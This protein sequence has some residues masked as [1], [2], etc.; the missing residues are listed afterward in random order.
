[1][2]EGRGAAGVPELLFTVRVCTPH[3]QGL[4]PQGNRGSPL[5]ERGGR[6]TRKD[7]RTESSRTSVPLVFTAEWGLPLVG[8]SGALF[9]AV[10]WLPIEVASLVADHRL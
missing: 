9:T 3:L 8:A 10:C 5:L 4:R 1:M 2:Q 6:T 7:S